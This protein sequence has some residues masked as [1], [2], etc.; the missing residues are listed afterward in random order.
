MG[1]G[2]PPG[3]PPMPKLKGETAHGNMIEEMGGY[4]HMFAHMSD[5]CVNCKK[6]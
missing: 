3:A 5:Y 1:Q 6:K 4:P 2:V